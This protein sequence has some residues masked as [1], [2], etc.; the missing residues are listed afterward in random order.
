MIQRLG[1]YCLPSPLSKT[2]TNRFSDH[3]QHAQL[4]VNYTTICSWNCLQDLQSFRKAVGIDLPVDYTTEELAATHV[5]DL[6]A[7]CAASGLAPGAFIGTMNSIPYQYGSQGTWDGISHVLLPGVS[8]E[9]LA[10]SKIVFLACDGVLFSEKARNFIKHISH[11]HTGK[12]RLPSKICS[13]PHR[14]LEHLI[15]SPRYSSKSLLLKNVYYNH[16]LYEWQKYDP[17]IHFVM[18][19]HLQWFD[20][21]CFRDLLLYPLRVV[22]S[23]GHGARL[24]GVLAWLKQVMGAHLG[25][26]NVKFIILDA[27]EAPYFKHRLSSFNDNRIREREGICLPRP[28]FTVK[29]GSFLVKNLEPV[30][31][32]L[33][34]SRYSTSLETVLEQNDIQENC[35]SFWKS[36]NYD[37]EVEPDKPPEHFRILTNRKTQAKNM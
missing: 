7:Q 36:T 3:A 23:V 32:L 37:L 35:K 14:L 15:C 4:P 30:Q 9:R 8:R 13:L 17:D 10:R 21:E 16:A 29:G 20:A 22:G 31:R 12:L 26:E 1:G 33:E 6:H 19:D 24:R 2:S 5:T 11:Q 18:I 25:I 28:L 34:N 27:V